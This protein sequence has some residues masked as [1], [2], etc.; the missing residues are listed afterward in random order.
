MINIKENEKLN[1]LIDN[2]ILILEFTNKD[3]DKKDYFIPN[4]KV[5]QIAEEITTIVNKVKREMIAT[6]M[7]TEK[8]IEKCDIF[9]N[10]VNYLENISANYTDIALTVTNYLTKNKEQVL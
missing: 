8:K 10:I 2:V 1:V 5:M 9:T 4:L 7:Y 6:N 3:A